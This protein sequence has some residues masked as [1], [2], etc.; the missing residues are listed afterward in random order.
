MCVQNESFDIILTSSEDQRFN[1]FEIV[2]CCS[3]LLRD[4][5]FLKYEDDVN[6]HDVN[7]DNLIDSSR[8][9]MMHQTT[10]TINASQF[11]VQ[12]VRIVQVI[13]QIVRNDVV[14]CKES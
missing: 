7:V 3:L 5:R 12:V 8:R 2:L 6:Q 9:S 4:V 10:C 13:S 14:Q 1:R 11:E